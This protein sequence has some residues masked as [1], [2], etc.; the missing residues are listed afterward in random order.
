MIIKQ[1]FGFIFIS[2]LIN[3]S[4]LGMASII[5]NDEYTEKRIVYVIVILSTNIAHL[6]RRMILFN[7]NNRDKKETNGS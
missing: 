3:M 1:K 5:L 2:L 4:G 6:I 7:F